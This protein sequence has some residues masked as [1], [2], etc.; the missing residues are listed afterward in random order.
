MRTDYTY[1]AGRAGPCTAVV[2]V[3]D[4]QTE[5]FVGLSFFLSRILRSCSAQFSF[6]S[7]LFIPLRFLGRQTLQRKP[8]G[9]LAEGEFVWSCP[10]RCHALSH[11]HNAPQPQPQPNTPQSPNK[12]VTGHDHELRRSRGPLRWRKKD[13]RFTFLKM[14]AYMYIYTFLRKRKTMR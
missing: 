7:P 8:A 9:R 5:Q 4:G 12:R 14:E 1:A 13:G 11:T 3:R 2:V 10:C 6:F